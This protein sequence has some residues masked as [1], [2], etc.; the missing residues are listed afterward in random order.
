[1]LSPKVQA[2]IAEWFGEA[3]A[4]VKAC[5][6]TV[7]KNH[8]QI[9]H[10]TDEAYF[11]RVAYWE[12]PIADCGDSRGSKCKDYSQWTQAWTEIKG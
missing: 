2:Q 1:V 8:C 9:F 7:A 12:T 3:P 10:A 6:L 4:N 11:K 5:A